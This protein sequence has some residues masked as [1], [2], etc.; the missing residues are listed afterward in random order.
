MSHTISFSREREINPFWEFTS[1]EE[2]IVGMLA[3]GISIVSEINSKNG[4]LKYFFTCSEDVSHYRLLHNIHENEIKHNQC[5]VECGIHN[6]CELLDDEYAIWIKGSSNFRYN[7]FKF[8]SSDFFQG[9][10]SLCQNFE[11][12]FRDYLYGVPFNMRN[13]SYVLEE[14]IMMPFIMSYDVP[15]T[16]DNEEEEMDD[17]NI[18][19]PF[20]EMEDSFSFSDNP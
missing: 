9:L 19:S 16:L 18:L 20:G 10:I 12:D 8:S 17:E 2:I 13:E 4:G 5:G 1:D 11:V 6:K 7:L 15:D 14:Y 3:V